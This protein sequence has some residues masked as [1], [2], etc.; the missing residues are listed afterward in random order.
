MADAL[1]LTHAV[2]Q[3]AHKSYP[4]H[5]AMKEAADPT[6]DNGQKLLQ[7]T[8]AQK[9]VDQHWNNLQLTGHQ[10]VEYTKF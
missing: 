6:G 2:K 7:D 10:K 8:Q 5:E 9:E 4:R 1:A 3:V